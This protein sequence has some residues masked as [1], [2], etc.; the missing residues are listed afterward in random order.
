[1]SVLPPLPARMICHA[2]SILHPHRPNPNT[3]LVGGLTLA[4]DW[5]CPS[6]SCASCEVASHRRRRLQYRRDEKSKHIEYSHTYTYRERLKIHSECLQY[7]SC[8]SFLVTLGGSISNALVGTGSPPHGSARPFL[9][10]LS[11]LR[12]NSANRV[13]NSASARTSD[14]EYQDG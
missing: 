13:L 3:P 10:R 12:L 7:S 11:H 6:C 1:M 14:S 9:M 8:Y 2:A 5:P 4:H